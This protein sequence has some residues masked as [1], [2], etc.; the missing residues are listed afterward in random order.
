MRDDV[1]DDSSRAHDAAA[2]WLKAA[3]QCMSWD[4]QAFLRPAGRAR[5]VPGHTSSR[6]EQQQASSPDHGSCARYHYS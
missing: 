5:A 6:R 2:G 3:L 1:K 4:A